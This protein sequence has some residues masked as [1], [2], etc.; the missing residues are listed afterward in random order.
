MHALCPSVLR[1]LIC[2]ALQRGAVL[3]FA[4]ASAVQGPGGASCVEQHCVHS[5]VSSAVTH[6]THCK[7]TFRMWPMLPIPLS[8][9]WQSQPMH[10]SGLQRLP[11]RTAAA[12]AQ[13]RR[14]RRRIRLRCRHMQR[15]SRGPARTLLSIWSRPSLRPCC[16]SMLPARHLQARQG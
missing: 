4:C 13:H 5:T 6:S 16:H 15:R 11:L 9:H 3:C 8:D 1:T 14:R 2:S 10:S 7:T 12:A